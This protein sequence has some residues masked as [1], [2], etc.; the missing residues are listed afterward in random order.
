MIYAAEHHDEL[1]HL[2]RRQDRR[3]IALC[4][5]D[6]HDDLRGL[7]I[8]RRRGVA[9][10]IGA[11][12]GGRAPLDEGNFL[13]WAVLERRIER[14][15]WV[16][17]V[18]GGRAWDTG[19]VRYE[20][21]LSGWPRRLGHLLRRGDELR[22]GFEEL[23]LERWS[24]LRP[25]EHL[26]LDWDALASV[27]DDAAGIEAR[28]ARLLDRLGPVVPPASYV[29]HSPEYCHPS[30]PQFRQLLGTLECRF[31]QPVEWLSPGLEQGRLSPRGRDPRPPRDA[32]TRAILFLRRRGIY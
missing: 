29:V 11:L 15:R 6:F 17:P 24:G 20:G 2:W 14:L 8:G 7:M 32:W 31:A 23:R 18:P 19:I 25:G 22:L 16:H 28:A 27:L 21:D 12:A 5:V 10:P 1:L 13:A 26:S 9:Y 3:G 4:H 30:L